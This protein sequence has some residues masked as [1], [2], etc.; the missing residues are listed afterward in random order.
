MPDP[1]DT[2]TGRFVFKTALGGVGSKST[3]DFDCR[4]CT[5]EEAA[6]NILCFAIAK[7]CKGRDVEYAMVAERVK[8]RE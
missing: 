4:G 5:A 3:S 7:T 1:S 8:V 6:K 2:N